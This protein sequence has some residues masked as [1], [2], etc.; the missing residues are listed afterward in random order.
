MPI[1]FDL[2]GTLGHFSSGFVLLRQALGDIWGQAPT[3]AELTLCKGSTDWEI[4]DDL[5]RMR[6]GRGLNEADYAIYETAC[7]SHFQR[8]FA[9]GGWE[10]EAFA[11]VLEG[12][13]RLAQRW[14]VW[15]VS[16]NAPAVLTFKAEVLG[17]DSSIPRLGSLPRHDRAGLLKRALQDCPGP[18]LYVGDR[19]HDLEAA[20]R[21]GLP[22]VG[23]GDAVPGVHACVPSDAEA[24]RLVAAVE[25]ALGPRL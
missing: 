6:F 24:D 17:I 8:A 25:A 22:F 18:H 13:H 20:Q 2:D 12:M 9:P 5:H 3:P 11:G 1:C 4:V 14:P 7:L 16:G 15:L 23:V 21:A 19:P 10:A